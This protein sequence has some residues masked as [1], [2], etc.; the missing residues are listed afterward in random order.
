LAATFQMSAPERREAVKELAAEG[1]SNREIGGILSVDEKAVR[2]DG[3]ELSA[4]PTKDSV[5]PATPIAILRKIP[6]PSTL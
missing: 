1:H 2:N 5:K 4:P 3:A 6:R